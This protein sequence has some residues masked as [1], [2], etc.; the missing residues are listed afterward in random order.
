MRNLLLIVVYMVL[1]SACAASA[2]SP[3]ALITPSPA[4][5]PT[6]A[7]ITPSPVAPSP[8][9][10]SP[11][12]SGPAHPAWIALR[13]VGEPVEG[14]ASISLIDADTGEVRESVCGSGAGSGGATPFDDSF[15][16]SHDGNWLACIQSPFGPVLTLVSA[17]DPTQQLTWGLERSPPRNSS[18]RWKVFLA[19]SPRE[20]VLAVSV[21]SHIYTLVPD[22]ETTPQVLKVCPDVPC[23]AIAWS[24]DGTRLATNDARGLSLLDPASGSETSVTDEGIFFSGSTSATRD[25][26]IPLQNVAFSPDGEQIAYAALSGIYI[27]PTAGGGARR[28]V[29][30]QEFLGIAD[31][32][33]L[34]DGSAIEFIDPNGHLARAGVDEADKPYG[35]MVEQFPLAARS[36]PARCTALLELTGSR[37]IGQIG[38]PPEGPIYD[39]L[40]S[41]SGSGA[42]VRLTDSGVYGPIV[43]AEGKS[44]KPVLS[45]RGPAAWAPGPIRAPTLALSDPPQRGCAVFELQT[46]LVERRFDP[47]PVDGIY[48]PATAAAVRAF[49]QANGLDIDGVVGPAT[50]AALGG[51]GWDR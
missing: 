28:L 7:P 35:N 34:A 47:G 40:L 49:Q 39:L 19:W 31:L 13:Q 24:P 3:A 12:T 45:A 4:A 27:V 29:Q 50:W 6:A 32:A 26:D 25:I 11:V 14:L 16:W 36:T 37:A 15:A 30:P 1:L 10:P 48:G 2:P 21:G 44:P 38:Y 22:P 42:T 41:D 5:T 33:W 23:S 18:Q 20:P 17:A 8:A 43:L 51:W 46:R 9:A